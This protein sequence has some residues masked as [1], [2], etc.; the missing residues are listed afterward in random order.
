MSDNIEKKLEKEV[1]ACKEETEADAEKIYMILRR[2]PFNTRRD[3]QC[4]IWDVPL[5]KPLV[6]TYSDYVRDSD[7]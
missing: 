1:K 4:K 7:G 2:L 5:T 6:R 3:L